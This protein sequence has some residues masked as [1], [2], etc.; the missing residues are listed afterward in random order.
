MAREF[1]FRKTN[2]LTDAEKEQIIELFSRVSGKK[3]DRDRFDRKYL[4]TPLGYSYHGLM[5]IDSRIV[6]AYNV[7]PYQYRYFDKK[8]I[9]GLSVDTMIDE[10][11]RGGPFNLLKMA[12]M[13]YNAMKRD[14]ICFILGFPNDNAYEFTKRVLGWQDI[15]ELDSYVL[16]RNIGAIFPKMKFLNLFS[17][18]F[19]KII[20][21]LPKLQLWDEHNYYIEKVVDKNFEKQRYNE[22][23]STV[24]LSNG[25][26]CIYKIRAR[27]QIRVL[28]VIDVCPLTVDIFDEAVR[29]VY[30]LNAKSTDLVIYTGKLN[31]M[32]TKLI[33]M[34]RLGRNRMVGK[35]LNPQLVDN[36]IFEIR[37]WNVNTSNDDSEETL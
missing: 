29:K 3:R 25:G 30:S 20:V 11:H 37:N 32:P 22:R 21:S 24:I 4:Y 19:A 2:Q 34:P 28:Y 10:Q 26:K 18:I 6:G 15:G 23:Y 13:V 31:F 14:N 27:D 7:I 16:P 12:T 9:F 35:V 5:V 36:R 17:R 33:K 1:I 8:I